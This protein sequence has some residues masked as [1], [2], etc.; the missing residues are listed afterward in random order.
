MICKP[1]QHGAAGYSTQHKLHACSPCGPNFI[2]NEV[3]TFMRHPVQHSK[4]MAVEMKFRKSTSG[5]MEARSAEA[6]KN[7]SFRRGCTV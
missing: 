7:R 3:K 5:Y 2:Q 6:F 1:Q 4:H